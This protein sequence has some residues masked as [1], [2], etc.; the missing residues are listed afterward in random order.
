MR[1]TVLVTDEEYAKIKRAAGLIPL[2]AWLK[3]LAMCACDADYLREELRKKTRRT[4]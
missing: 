1:I 4:L 3:H 2:S